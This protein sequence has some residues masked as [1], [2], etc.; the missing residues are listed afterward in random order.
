MG[1]NAEWVQPLIR[2]GVGSFIT[3]ASVFDYVVATGELILRKQAPVLGGYDPA[4]Y[5]QHR[6][7]ASPTTAYACPSP[8]CVARTLLATAPLRR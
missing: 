5:E 7:W 3:P 6:T 1:A 2:V 8:W 4:D